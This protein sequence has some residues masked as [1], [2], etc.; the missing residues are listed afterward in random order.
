VAPASRCSHPWLSRQTRALRGICGRDRSAFCLSGTTPPTARS[1]AKPQL[2]RR[3]RWPLPTGARA[4]RGAS[5]GQGQDRRRSL[6][7]E[8]WK[9]QGLGV[10]PAVA[11]PLLPPPGDGKGRG[12]GLDLGQRC[13]PVPDLPLLLP[14][15]EGTASGWHGRGGGNSS[16]VR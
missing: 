11:S 9:G 12:L 13:L 16:S 10:E 6:A 7:L 14:A 3:L 5:A 2:S 8:R 1:R 15:P 4:R